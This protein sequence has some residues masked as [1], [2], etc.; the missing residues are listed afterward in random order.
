MLG[1]DL[2]CLG[3]LSERHPAPPVHGKPG[4]GYP[5]CRRGSRARSR[6]VV[7]P[8]DDH[9]IDVRCEAVGLRRGPKPT[10]LPLV[11]SSSRAAILRVHGHCRRGTETDCDRQL[12]DGNWR[13]SDSGHRGDQEW[14][15]M[16]QRWRGFAQPQPVVVSVVVVVDPT[17]D[18]RH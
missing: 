12:R 17:D 3:E 13:R 7:E 1:W 5:G 10:R 18:H 15:A 2:A 8:A 16:F 4:R 9:V 14:G 6:C 11:S